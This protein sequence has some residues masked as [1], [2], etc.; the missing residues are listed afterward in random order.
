MKQ[1][2]SEYLKEYR[3]TPKGKAY[4]DEY[5]ARPE[6]IAKK[7][8]YGERPEVKAYVKEWKLKN[9]YGITTEE[10]NKLFD[11]QNGCC[12]T[13]GKHQSEFKKA[14][15]VDHNH[16]TGEVRGLLCSPCNHIIGLCYEDIIILN[17]IINYL[18][19][20]RNSI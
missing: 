3:K 1:N 8:A 19:N 11:K 15:V 10:Y 13:C 2:R 7:K 16:N 5:N 4:M 18:N 14:L 6:V 17:N 12:A 20:E 9:R